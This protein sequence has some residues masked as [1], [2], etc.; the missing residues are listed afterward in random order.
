MFGKKK[1]K[2]EFSDREELLSSLEKTTD[3]LLKTNE[4]LVSLVTRLLTE[5]NE[6]KHCLTK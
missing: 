3:E 2:A 5:T 6:M 4:E 1:A